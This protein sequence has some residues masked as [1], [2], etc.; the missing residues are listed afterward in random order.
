[1]TQRGLARAGLVVTI[2]FLGSRVLGWVRLVVIAN[3]FG[4]QA[5][6]DAYFAAFRIPDLIFQ[7]VAAGAIA[8]ALVPVLSSLLVAGQPSRAW[9]VTSTV[10]NLMLIGLVVFS[11]FVA[12][13]APLLVP[14]L[15]P[16]FDAAT[17]ELTVK[18]TRM[19]LL[20]P[21]FLGLGAVASSVLN[22]ENRF[23]AAAMAPIA[24][25]LCIIA[26]ALLLAPYIGIDALA[27]GVVI[28]SFANLVVQMPSMRGRFH[29]SL[30]ID[31]RD[32]AARQALLLMVPRA[33]GLG[34]TQITFA[35]NTSLA[36]GIGVGAVVAYN[37][38]FT[39]LQIP[40]GVVG[41]PLGVVL[42]PAMSRAHAA[43][44]IAEY[45]R[46]VTQ[47]MRLLLWLTMFVGVVGIALRYQT[48]VLLFGGFDERALSLTARTLAFFYLG[49][50]AHSLNVIL[51]RA[52]YSAQDTRTPVIVAIGSVV[53]NVAVS[54]ATVGTLGLSGLA[55]GIAIGGWSET[56]V[57]A[58][59][60]RRRTPQ[61]ALQPIAS[62]G[63][64][65]FIG[66]LMAALAAGA[67]AT[68]MEPILHVGPRGAALAELI[69]AGSAAAAIFLLY[70]RL[71]RIPE[72]PSAFGLLR[73]AL[74][75]G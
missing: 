53:V 57:L 74:H 14:W 11:V 39:I 17:T 54:I 72:L 66:A 52:F 51:T 20:S 12:V 69:V 63:F 23:G 9:R 30:G 60:L 49:L 42:L 46:L 43:G 68:A 29:Y 37:V 26:L 56:A 58:V 5:D 4:A 35:V 65:S 38:A 2:A 64:V 24:Y 10:I 15:V 67:I 18:L 1:V 3:L 45:G 32:S 55:L 36:T 70:S 6:L 13:F 33:I 47:S 59:I 73:S 28:G 75:R 19:M 71:V 40:L 7:L 8:S 31:I 16:G 44:D 25:N 48:V 21:I 22:A 61:V 62:G 34:V 27:V 41:F 50:P